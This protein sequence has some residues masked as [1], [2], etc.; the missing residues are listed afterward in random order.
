MEQAR[1][2]KRI[3]A[4]IFVTGVSFLINYLISF[5]LAPYITTA[6]GTEAYGFVALAKNLAVYATY[7]TIALNS[8]ATRY[9]SLEYHRG[10][11]KQANVY[12]SS[13]YWGD[14][15]FA[16]GIFAAAC[17]GILFLEHLLDIPADI[18]LDVKLLFAFVFV[19]FWLVTTF[20]A[21]ESGAYIANRLDLTGV[22]KGV[23]YAVEAAV[24]IGLFLAFRAHVFYVGIGIL[25][26]AVVIALSNVWICRRYT[27]ELRVSRTD[28]RFSAV[29]TL[30]ANGI[31]SSVSSLGA[32]LN[33]GLDLAV[34]NLMISPLA[35]GQLAI[36]ESISVIFSSLYNMVGEAFKPGFLKLYSQGD[37]PRLVR[38]FK[39]AVKAT[40]L[41]TN[42]F[43]AGFLALGTTYYRLWLPHEDTQLLFRLTMIVLG[44][45]MLI[46]LEAPLFNIYTLTL[47]RKVSCMFTLI[48]G[49]LNVLSMYVLIRF[50]HMGIYAVVLTT[51]VLQSVIHLLPHPLYMAHVLKLPWHTFYPDILRSLLSCGAMCLAFHGLRAL[52]AP[53]GWLTMFACVP[54]Y[55]VCG[56]ALHALITL[57]RSD[58][59]AL[60]RHFKGR[61]RGRD[62]GLPA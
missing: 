46:G 39:S 21:Y 7:L 22:F 41:V 48:T 28:Y 42:L 47:T 40:G 36:T 17:C 1:H 12:F 51:L 44:S 54:F 19:K 61:G 29:K 27:G 50:F 14:L 33:S 62:A 13:V 6:V 37:M 4:T 23:S 60:L 49:F 56:T 11:M 18:V 2:Y 58:W 59:R 15:I 5:F 16:T 53:Q 57:N 25:A 52:Y 32:M 9:I 3:A 55:V 45:G 35:M 30:V 24:L 43:F 26:A 31:W 34:C 10:D 38:E 8:Y 20:S